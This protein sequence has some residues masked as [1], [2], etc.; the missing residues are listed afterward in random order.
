[1][2]VAPLA[3]T[4]AFGSVVSLGASLMFSR[5][6]VARP[7][8]IIHTNDLHSHLNH[9]RD[10]DRGGYAAVKATIDSLKLRAMNDKIETLILDA[11]D[12]SEDS[13]FYLANRGL[14]SWKALDA[15]GYDA[16]TIGNHDWL[17]GMKNLDWVVGQVRPSFTLLGANFIFG[18]EWNNLVRHMRQ[19]ITVRRAGANIVIYG[20]TTDDFEFAWQ[21]RPGF[22]FEPEAS[23]KEDLPKYASGADYV[24]ALT[25]LGLKT[26]KMVISRTRGIDLVVGGHSHTQLNEPVYAKNVN[27]KEIPIV[28]TGM[29]GEFVGDLLVD[30]EPGKPL[31]ILRYQLIPVYST[32]PKDEHMNQVVAHARE[33]LD[34]DYG[35]DWLREVVGHSEVP[36]ENAYYKGEATVWSRFVADSIREAGEAEAAID[37]TEFEGVDQPAGP[38]TREQL[39]ILYPRIFEFEKRYG[40]TVWTALAKGFVIKLALQATIGAGQ[41]V[42]TSGITYDLD[43]NGKPSNFLI[44]GKPISNSR[45]YKVALPE[46]ILRGAFGVSKH[47]KLVITRAHDT[48]ISV[49]E[50]TERKLRAVGTIRK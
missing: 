48:G 33:E 6:S 15:M 28:Q 19:A 43:S 26:D 40:W 38:I 5:A 50:A 4:L 49:W 18:W 1:M 41:P 10:R 11:G 21:T 29:H 27:G 7:L 8:Q 23:V 13:Q 25:H 34:L 44:G 20:L 31:Q 14:E 17:M 39:F 9:A 46:G 2:R 24:I 47:L 32:G 30:I 16:V 35:Y 37:A 22:I 12:F 36:L 42:H 45:N 3:V